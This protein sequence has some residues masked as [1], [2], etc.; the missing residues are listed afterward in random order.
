VTHVPGLYPCIGTANELAFRRRELHQSRAPTNALPVSRSQLLGYRRTRLPST[1]FSRVG[2][3]ESTAAD[4][5]CR[6]VGIACF[7]GG[8]NYNVNSDRYCPANG[9]GGKS[10]GDAS[11]F[12]GKSVGDAS[13]F[14]ANN[15][16]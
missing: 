13:G 1:Y 5:R 14:G 15:A 16:W 2:A 10:V 9:F 4:L 6:V 3:R 12:G 7:L 8:A 11:G